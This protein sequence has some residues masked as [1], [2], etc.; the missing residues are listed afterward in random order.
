[1]LKVSSILFNTW[2]KVGLNY[3]LWKG[4]GHM[5]EGLSGKGDIDVLVDERD[6]SLCHKTL[7]EMGFLCCQSQNICNVESVYDWLGFDY[8][9]GRMIHVHL[10]YQIVIGGKN[11]KEF[12]L[13]WTSK[14]LEC[15][16]LEDNWNI[17]V[18]NPNLE[19]ITRYVIMGIESSGLTEKKDKIWEEIYFI[20]SICDDQ[21]LYEFLLDFF[22]EDAQKMFDYIKKTYFTCEDYA[23][24]SK[25][26]RR[27]LKKHIRYSWFT[28]VYRKYNIFLRTSFD[29]MRNKLFSADVIIRKTPQKG[30]L[31]MAFLGQDGAGKS[32]VSKD[33]QKWLSW[34]LE[35]K[36]FYLGSGDGF[37]S[38][39]RSLYKYLSIRK[40]PF[41]K[42]ICSILL[43]FQYSHLA[44]HVYFTVKRGTEY[45]KKGGIAIFDRF[46]QIL[47]EGIN[48]GPKIANLAKNKKM[49]V[50]IEAFVGFCAK[51]EKMW[52]TKTVAIEPDLVFKLLLSPDESFRRKPEE[53]YSMIKNKHIIIKNLEFVKSA[54]YEIDAEQNYDVEVVEI[55]RI[56]WQKIQKS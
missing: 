26:V 48:D 6:K 47:C 35:T 46:P 49:N 25:I 50:I 28:I 21:S 8:D 19:L 13:P 41:Y 2:N 12:I 54:V 11:I 4:R 5:E 22:H 42:T 34:K 33:I 38:W 39:Y 51:R 40:K 15:R 14:S 18:Q 44:K 20:K 55:K 9:T 31:V 17:Y 53:N 52:L 27:N 56:I 36:R 10:Y 24:F 16:Q 37:H 23:K 1:M 43:L 32:T 29:K 7:Y 3:C 30:G 45:S